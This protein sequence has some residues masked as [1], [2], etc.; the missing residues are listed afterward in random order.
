MEKGKSVPVSRIET[1]LSGHLANSLVTLRTELQTV[2]TVKNND[3]G[4]NVG[5]CGHSG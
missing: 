4:E 3:P 5:N 1:G 2:M